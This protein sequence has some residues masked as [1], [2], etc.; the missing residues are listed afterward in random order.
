M[1]HNIKDIIGA[2]LT[3]SDGDI[4]KVRDFLFDDTTWTFRYV[5]ADTGG[6]LTGRKVLI[7]PFSL[8][9]PDLRGFKGHVPVK[10]TRQQLEAA[11]PLDEHAP[12]SRRYELELA[13][14]YV[15]PTYWEGNMLWGYRPYPS[16]VQPLTPEEVAEHQKEVQEI[17]HCHLRSAREVTGYHLGA[18]DGEIGH[19][20]DYLAD[21][22]TWAIRFL[23]VDTKNWWPGK[24]VLI[25]PTLVSQVN[26]DQKSVTVRIPRDQIKNS[27]AYHPDQP[28]TAELEEQIHAYYGYPK[29]PQEF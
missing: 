13:R 11:P 25:A 14:F 4:G 12:V 24:Q 26:W 5:V 1:L 15:V 2:K 22:Q 28:I 27:P 23:I 19:V 17:K 16:S 29:M 7:S 21:H 20:K 18:M 3:A 9:D 8:G 6:W 10:L